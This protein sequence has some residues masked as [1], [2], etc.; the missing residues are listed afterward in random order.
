M[1]Q[2]GAISPSGRQGRRAP[3]IPAVGLRVPAEELP[4]VLGPRDAEPT[5]SIVIP[6]KN[7]RETCRGLRKAP[8]KLRSDPRRWELDRQ[9]CQCRGGALRPDIT[10]IG[11]TR[12]GKGNALACG[13]AAATGDFIVMIDADGSNDAAEIPRFVSCSEGRGRLRQRVPVPRWRGKPRHQF[14]QEVRQL[15]AQQDC[16]PALWNSIHGPLLRLQR[17]PARVPRSHETQCNRNRS[18]RAWSDA[19]GRRIRGGDA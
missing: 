11:Q 12:T 15:L 17:L 10:V 19:L 18:L 1:V 3:E 7:E 9:H 4:R 13:F 16:Q 8:R 14:D 5:V 2:R 6:A